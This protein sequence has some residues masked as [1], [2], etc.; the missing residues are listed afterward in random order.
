MNVFSFP[1][2]PKVED[3]KGWVK[4]E[5]KQ[6]RSEQEKVLKS[7]AGLQKKHL[8]DSI[9]LREELSLL[10]ERYEVLHNMLDSD[11]F[12]IMQGW[13]INKDLEKVEDALESI[14]NGKVVVKAEDPTPEE[15]EKVPVQLDNPKWLRPF[16]MLTE[17]YALPRY[18]DLDPTFIVGPIFVIY[19]AFMLTDAV[20]GLALFIGGIIIAKKFAKYNEGLKY[21][22]VNI[23]AMG[24]ICTIF[25]ILTG[26][27]FGDLPQY[28]FGLEKAPALWK[29]PLADPLY[30][31]IIAIGVAVVHLNFGLILGVIE[32][33]RKKAW[34]DL[35]KERLVWFLIQLGVVLMVFKVP[36]GKWLFGL[37]VL[38]IVV[39]SG[40]LGLLSI[41]GLMGDMISYSRLFALALSTSGIALA[42]N[43][44]ANLVLEIPA[45]G[46]VAAI[47]IFIIGH[48]FGFVMNT[49]GAFVHSLR[50]QFV[51]FFGRFYEGGGDRFAPLK[52]ERVY[53]EVKE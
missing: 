26:S 45:V 38:L 52:E 24:A 27:Y 29:D 11:N 8:T 6:N 37:T 16:E 9:A 3:L 20:Y 21:A 19:A 10:K 44:L 41:T 32:D 30:F 48:L 36:F 43:L 25:G 2:L 23:I 18:K 47:I 51:E 50:L 15:Q 4:K 53:T 28:L 39:L 31:L 1:T 7:I 17:L 42:V 14:T 40:P 35:V 33:V 49:I 13:V 22:M 34:K 5:I 12:F 46:I